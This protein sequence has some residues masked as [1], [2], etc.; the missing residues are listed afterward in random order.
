MKAELLNDVYRRISDAKLDGGLVSTKRE[1]RDLFNVQT[2]HG[3]C[4]LF[5]VP[6]SIR[7]ISTVTPLPVSPSLVRQ[8][9]L[10]LNQHVPRVLFYTSDM[11]VHN[12]VPCPRYISLFYPH[13]QSVGMDPFNLLQWGTI[14]AIFTTMLPSGL[15]RLLLLDYKK[16][17][18][19]LLMKM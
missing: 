18:N 11:P 12:R 6:C 14:N 5:H 4:F 9:T 15:W 16:G 2:P 3:L 7:A 17:I 8:A 13:F 10:P 19:R 1:W